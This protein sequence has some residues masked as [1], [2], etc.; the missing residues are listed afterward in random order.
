MWWHV[1]I[2]NLINLKGPAGLSNESGMLNR[3]SVINRIAH[4]L[5][6][7]NRFAETLS[8]F[9]VFGDLIC[10]MPVKNYQNMPWKG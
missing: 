3:Y 8:K 2:V 4:G 5:Y 6:T 7:T 10:R 1:M 9:E